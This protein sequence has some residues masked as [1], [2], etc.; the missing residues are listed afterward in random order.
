MPDP[1]LGVTPITFRVERDGCQRRGVVSR[2]VSNHELL[3]LLPACAVCIVYP[4]DD[5]A[6]IQCPAFVF[7]ELGKADGLSWWFTNRN[8]QLFCVTRADLLLARKLLP[9]DLVFGGSFIKD[10]VPVDR[11][12][13]FTA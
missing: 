6:A 8:D 11:F 12:D 9:A 13:F 5:D 1:V 4:H 10:V 7:I 2:C 3:G